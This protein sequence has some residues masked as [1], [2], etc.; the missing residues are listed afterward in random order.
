MVS[1]PWRLL[2][3]SQSVF[4]DLPQSLDLLSP[5]EKAL[6]YISLTKK[7]LDAC[8]RR[9]PMTPEMFNLELDE[10]VFTNGADKEVM[11]RFAVRHRSGGLK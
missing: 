9:V 5:K 11:S 4:E 3:L 6:G 1:P 2:R 10:L 8:P 7:A